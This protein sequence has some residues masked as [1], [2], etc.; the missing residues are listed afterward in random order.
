MKILNSFELLKFKI[1]LI[2]FE[3]SDRFV[4]AARD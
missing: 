1:V 4:G 3:K 2:S